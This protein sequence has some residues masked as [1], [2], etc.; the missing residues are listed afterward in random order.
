MYDSHIHTSFSADCETP[1]E[2]VL[3]AAIKFGVK[4]VAITDHIDYKY[5]N[6]ILFEFD[7]AEYS[8]VIERMQKEYEGTLEILKGVELGIKPDVLELCEK[9]THTESFDFIIASMHGCQGEDFYFGDYFG[10][11]TP[12]EAMQVYLKEMLS[13]IKQFSNFDVLGHIDLPKRYNHDV[14]KLGS[15]PL[16]DDYRMIFNWLVA[17][18]K[19]IELNTSGLRQ[20]V[21]I[22][23]PDKKILSAYYECGGRKITLGSDSHSADTLCE[24]FKYALK[25]L[26]EIGFEYICSY[27]NRQARYHSIEALLKA[28]E[29]SGKS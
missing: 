20:E 19:G 14:A 12:V 10:N 16:L 21:G 26:A 18:D 25:L 2:E 22:Q 23:F 13:L 29:G 3:Q 17:H 24:D 11:K 5:H 1:I 7:T 15:D 6:D 4:A 27:K 28:H 8:Q 9:L